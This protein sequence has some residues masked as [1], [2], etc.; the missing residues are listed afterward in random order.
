L[1]LSSFDLQPKLGDALSISSS[2][3]AV[4]TISCKKKVFEKQRTMDVR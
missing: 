2:E 3:I 4:C 1:A